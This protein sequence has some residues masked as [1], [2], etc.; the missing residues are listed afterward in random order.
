[1]RN[2]GGALIVL[3]LVLLALAGPGGGA[4]A[5][6]PGLLPAGQYVA[7][8]I[9]VKFRPNLSVNADVFARALGARA[10]GRIAGL[11]VHLLKVS[12]A[13]LEALLHSLARH[14][15]V[16]RVELNGI[17]TALAAPD[18]PHYATS[19]YP[20]SRNGCVTQWGFGPIQAAGAWDITRGWNT[21]KI[22]VVDTGIDT[23]NPDLPP[24]AAQVD[25]VNGDGDADDDN[26][27]GTHV[28]GIIGALTNNTIG[29]AGMNWGTLGGTGD[30]GVS[31]LAAKVLN[32]AGSGSYYAVMNGIMWAVQNGAHVINLSLGGSLPSIFLESAVVNAWQAGSVLACAAGNSGTKAKTYPAAYPEC[33]AVAATDQ[34]DRKASFSNWDKTWVDVA[35][36]GVAI[37]STMPNSPVYLTTQYAY[38][39]DYD[40][41]SGTSMATPFVAGLAGLRWT[42]W[43]ATGCATNS[44]IRN[45]IEATADRISGTGRY[46]AHGRINAYKAVQ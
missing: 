34:T 32:A 27:H 35:A 14:P 1:M 41:L 43:A 25:Y 18:D 45:K 23:S 37:L 11:D 40:A 30:P 38:K 19:C 6:S 2:L 4:P 39:Q 10:V 13:R 3:V 7:D 12:P 42:R 21:V 33:I 8:E 24:V 22:A 17:A 46:W 5:P 31:L 26:G 20:S 28:A 29:V 15:A 16:E 44:C 36:P 9:L